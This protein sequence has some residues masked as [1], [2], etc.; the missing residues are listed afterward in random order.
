M[1]DFLNSMLV[2]RKFTIGRFGVADC[3][4]NFAAAAD[5]VQQNLDLG[6]I[7]PAKS[8]VLDVKCVCVEEVVGVTDLTICIGNASAGAEFV[9]ALSC[10]ALNEV[11]GWILAT[12]LIPVVVNWTAATH[13]WIGADPTDNT[14]N[15]MSAGKWEVYV[16][17]INY[18]VE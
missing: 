6:A 8:K 14:W 1:A 11:V 5:H 16:T 4:F 2:T 10:D 9:A 3:D 18:D 15:D 7:I 12:L 13:I 17:Y